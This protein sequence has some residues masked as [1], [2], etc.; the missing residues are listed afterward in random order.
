MPSCYLSLRA[1]ATAHRLLVIPSGV[2][3][4][5]TVSLRHAA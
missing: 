4:S 5:L 3:E 1:T 2:E